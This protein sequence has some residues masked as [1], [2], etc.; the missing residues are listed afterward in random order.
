V[1]LSHSLTLLLLT[2]RAY[3]RVCVLSRRRAPCLLYTFCARGSPLSSSGGFKI[4]SSSYTKCRSSAA[5]CGRRSPRAARP[6][7]CHSFACAPVLISS[8]ASR[9]L[10]RTLIAARV[11]SQQGRLG[12][13]AAAASL[14]NCTPD[15]S[16]MLSTVSFAFAFGRLWV[17]L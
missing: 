2:A 15:T 3:V 5:D 4:G 1:R 12:A 14:R 13:C 10:R 6:P 8:A 11:P 9:A 17:I 7:L 16:T